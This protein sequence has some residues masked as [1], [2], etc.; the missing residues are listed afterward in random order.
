MGKD[1]HGSY[2]VSFLEPIHNPIHPVPKKK[3]LPNQTIQGVEGPVAWS[4]DRCLAQSGLR[5]LQTPGFSRRGKKNGTD[6]HE[7][8]GD[9]WVNI[10]YGNRPFRIDGIQKLE[11]VSH[12]FSC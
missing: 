6:P 12:S 10:A 11:S 9:G 7:Y 4:S 3:R 5:S 8:G 2:G 1:I